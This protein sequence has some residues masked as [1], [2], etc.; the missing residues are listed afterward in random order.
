MITLLLA[1]LLQ[2]EPTEHR[3]AV[4]TENASAPAILSLRALWKDRVLLN[5]PPSRDVVA[6]VLSGDAKPWIRA[7]GTVVLD[8]P[9]YAAEFGGSVETVTMENPNRLPIDA[10]DIQALEAAG[11]EYGEYLSKGTAPSEP[12]RATQPGLKAEVAEPLPSIRITTGDP[13][14]R[15]FAVGDVV[16]W[17]GHRKGTYRQRALSGGVGEAL[18]VSTVNGGAVLSRNGTVYG[19]DLD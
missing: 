2:S 18:A 5:P 11:R 9:L 3:M 6:L 19:I 7:G 16:P 1:L 8:L 12:T 15:G 14:L 10:Y 4:V 13:A 17:C